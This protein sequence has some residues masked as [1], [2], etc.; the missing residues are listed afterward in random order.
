MQPSAG[1][2]RRR[3]L[4]KGQAGHVGSSP[5]AR[6]KEEAKAVLLKL[7]HLEASTLKSRFP[8]YEEPPTPFPVPQKKGRHC[9]QWPLW[10][11]TCLDRLCQTVR[12]DPAKVWGGE[13]SGLDFHHSAHRSLEFNL[14][15]IG[16]IFP[17]GN[18]YICPVH[19]SSSQSLAYEVCFLPHYHP[20]HLYTPVMIRAMSAPTI[21]VIHLSVPNQII[22]F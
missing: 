22:T 1:L 19:C 7:R 9:G 13:S 18:S 6:S 21:A 20:L 5:S 11:G 10:I 14:E 8:E 12:E 4:E 16:V 2:V 3:E 17:W 15:Q